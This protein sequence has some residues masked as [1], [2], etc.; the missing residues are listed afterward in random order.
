MQ[1]DKESCR[2]RRRWTRTS[3]RY[4]N[5]LAWLRRLVVSGTYQVPASIEEHGL[6][7]CFRAHCEEQ[8]KLL[9]EKELRKQLQTDELVLKN[10][11]ANVLSVRIQFS[12]DEKR[13]LMPLTV[14]RDHDDADWHCGRCGKVVASSSLPGAAAVAEESKDQSTAA[15]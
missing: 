2:S 1:H 14:T 7:P 4:P 12:R 8:R 10:P 5:L 13:L 3:R 11:C 6:P 9:R 15:A